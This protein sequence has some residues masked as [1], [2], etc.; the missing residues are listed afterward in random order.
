MT[1]VR[2]QGFREPQIC[3]IPPLK[4][5]RKVKKCIE[6]GFSVY[7][8][9]VARRMVSRISCNGPWKIYSSLAPK[10][11]HKS[12]IVKMVNVKSQNISLYSFLET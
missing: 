7:L 2:K 5:S 11:S 12:Q 9:L 4:L 6:K 1:L 10:C 8:G 3:R